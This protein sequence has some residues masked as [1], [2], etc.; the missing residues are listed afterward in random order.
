MS[1]YCR[2]FPY[3]PHSFPYLL[4]SCISLVPLLQFMN[5]YFKF[6][7]IF[8]AVLGLHC[9]PW[10]FSSC[11]EWGLCSSFSAWASHCGGFSCCGAGAQWLCWTG[12]LAPWHVESSWTRG[13]SPA[14][15]GGLLTTGPPGESCEPILIH[16]HLLKSIVAVHALLYQSMDFDK[17]IKSGICSY[18]YTALKTPW[19]PT[20][21]TSHP[22]P[23]PGSDWFFC[24]LAFPEC[25]TIGIT[26]YLA[27]SDYSFFH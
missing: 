24:S 8:L 5:Q 20:L 27:F 17:C 19:A 1:R 14:L 7:F 26:Q 3:S 4:L 25:H 22:L 11:V 16:F 10:A 2:K 9:C 23:T 6:L 21:C 12:L 18:S 13:Q 15:A